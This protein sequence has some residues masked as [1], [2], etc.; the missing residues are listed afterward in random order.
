LSAGRDKKRLQ[1]K[2]FVAL[3]RKSQ[4]V[5]E[6]RFAMAKL[7]IGAAASGTTVRLTRGNEARLTLP[8]TRTAGYSW[9]I[10]SAESPVFSVEDAGFVPASGVGGTGVHRW[11]LKTLRPGRATL[12]MVYGRSWEAAAEAKQRFAVT[13]V[14]G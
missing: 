2:E 8:E 11:T 9:R 6:V 1:S 4:T 13:V 14:V 5:K 7:E 3:T 12:E 10:V